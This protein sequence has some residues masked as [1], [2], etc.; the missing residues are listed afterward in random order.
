MSILTELR[1]S[2]QTVLLKRGCFYVPEGKEETDWFWFK[3]AAAQRVQKYIEHFESEGWTL[4]SR[5]VVKRVKLS[6][7]DRK[8]VTLDSK[9]NVAMRLPADKGLRKDHPW[10]KPGADMYEV[11]A[12]FSKPNQPTVFELSDKHVSRLIQSG[13][14]PTGITLAE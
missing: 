6:E 12:W 5:P 4:R 7:E 2:N 13:R 3:A 1:R 11:R 10:Y 8:R 14:L 9:G